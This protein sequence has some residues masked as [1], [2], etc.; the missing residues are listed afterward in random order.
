MLASLVRVSTKDN[1]QLQGLHFRSSDRASK[2]IIIHFHGTWG[3]FYGNSFIDYFAE[4]YLNNGY[5]FLTVNTRGHD[6]GS[7]T[8]R[9]DDSIKDIEEWLR[10][11]AGQGY[12]KVIL[13][14]HSLGALKAIH[15]AS[16]ANLADYPIEV[17]GI[18]LLS[19]FDVVAFNCKGELD[20]REEKI[21]I[22]EALAGEDQNQLTPAELWD[23]WLLS[24]GTFLDLIGK[25]TK[26]DI[27]PFRKGN[28]DE[29][30]LTDLALPIFAVI[31]GDDFAAF[32]TPEAQYEQLKRLSNVEAALIDGGPHNFAG[33]ELALLAEIMPWLQT[34]SARPLR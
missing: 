5:S 18:I 21:A 27:F 25:D 30:A 32:P 28:L 3:N 15:F 19:P 26:A 34:I 11:A 1:V 4:S 23:M 24:V 14:G 9:F 17:A 8:E 13:Q 20:K 6:E 12:R 31:G 10:F 33:H 7:I 29:S 22:S 2:E 16:N